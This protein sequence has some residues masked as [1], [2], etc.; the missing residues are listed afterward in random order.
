MRVSDDL[1][2][3]FWARFFLHRYT[4]FLMIKPTILLTCF[5]LR[6]VFFF[7]WIDKIST[8][9]HLHWILPYG[10]K[11]L[12]VFNVNVCFVSPAAFNC[13][14]SPTMCQLRVVW[15]LPFSIVHQY[16]WT[17]SKPDK[18]YYQSSPFRIQLHLYSNLFCCKYSVSIIHRLHITLFV[19]FRNSISSLAGRKKNKKRKKKKRT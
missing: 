8:G 2:F 1:Q 10:T 9:I 18:T 7:F 16:E 15:P 4:H 14:N 5:P 12:L 11:L 3:L 19:Q 6:F 17:T 13:S